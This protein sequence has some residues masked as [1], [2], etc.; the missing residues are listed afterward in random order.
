MQSLKQQI[1]ILVVVVTLVLAVC[2]MIAVGL[3]IKKSSELA[4]ITKAKSDIATAKTIIDLK[5][6][7]PWHVVDGYLYKGEVKMNNNF[8]VVDYI[9]SLTGDTC[10]LFLGNTRVATT[11]KKADGQRA[12][13][14]HSSDVVAKKVLT[15]GKDYLGEAEVVG[16]KYQT[17][18]SPIYD[19]RG[20]IIGMFYVGISKKFYDQLLYES[21]WRMALIGTALTLLVFGGTLYF[22][23]KFIIEPLKLIQAETQKVAAGNIS[24][25]VAIGYKNEI[26]ELAHSFNQLVELIQ[27]L[28]QQISKNAGAVLPPANHAVIADGVIAD[29]ENHE[30][31][32]CE[33]LKEVKEI[34]EDW[35]ELPKGLNETTLQQILNYLKSRQGHL[36]VSEIAEEVKLTKVTVR[37]YLDFMEKCGRV[38]VEMQYG[39]IGRPLK[40]YTLLSNYRQ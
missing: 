25:S 38:K 10:T 1:T 9:S 4:A 14:T 34:K 31:T 32:V 2:F 26:G 5:Y 40:L 15:E 20:N 36:S 12:V 27:G 35:G 13:G 30:A 19:H 16:E 28:T 23:Q 24:A 11:I 7:G 39:P 6:P 29:T 22:T 37:R 21:L 8:E 17:A 18:Y 33:Q 3:Q